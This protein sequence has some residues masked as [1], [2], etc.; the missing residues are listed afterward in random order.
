MRVK[1]AE[2]DICQLTKETEALRK[3]LT[4]KKVK[5]LL[6]GGA[7]YTP[8]GRLKKLYRPPKNP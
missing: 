5:K 3:K 8:T 1:V 2:N 7:L 6:L 4:K